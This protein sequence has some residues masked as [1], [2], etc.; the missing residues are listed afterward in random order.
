[1]R[2]PRVLNRR[3]TTGRRG[4]LTILAGTATGQAIALLAAP[5]LSRLYTPSDLGVLTVVTA[6]AAALTPVAAMRLELAVP[7]PKSEHDAL[8]LVRLGLIS[9]GTTAVA[10]TVVV[11]VSRDWIADRFTNA[12]LASWLWFVP[13]V[14][15]TM[16][17]FLLLNQLAIRHRRYGAVGRRNLLSSACNVTTQLGAGLAGLRPGGLVVGL[18]VGQLVGATSLLAGANLRKQHDEDRTRTP[19]SGLLVRYRR[20]PLLLA[21]AGLLNTLGLQLPP[22]LVAYLYG[23]AAAG[24]LG[25]AQRVLVLPVMLVGQAVAQ[26]YLGELSRDVRMQGDR[27][28]SLFMRTSARLAVV[29]LVGVLPLLVLGPHLFGMVFGQSWIRSGSFAQA[30]ALGLGAQM[31]SSPLSQTL[32]VLGRQRAQLALDAMRLA[33]T[34]GSILASASLGVPVLGAVWS[35]GAA[36]A[37]CYTVGWLVNRRVITSATSGTLP[38]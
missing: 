15:A 14:G 6:L 21:P 18:A 36:L 30:L 27:T 19:L 22:L 8:R 2:L 28:R 38:G 31:V 16:A 3:L 9:A 12:H 37:I 24:W 7:L 4:V 25:L 1:M 13:A 26:V 5:V 20:F 10:G 29:A 11:A 23:S 34:A 33:F 32:I 35:L 17:S